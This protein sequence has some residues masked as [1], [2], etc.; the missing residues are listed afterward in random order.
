[1]IVK[2]GTKFILNEIEWKTLESRG[3]PFFL[4]N[5][6][7]FI[8]ENNVELV[9]LINGNY[10]KRIK[11]QDMILMFQ[12]V[13]KYS[14]TKPYIYLIVS[15]GNH[16]LAQASACLIMNKA[17]KVQTDMPLPIWHTINAGYK[18]SL[19]DD[20]SEKT[21]LLILDGMFPDSPQIKVEK[22]RDILF[23][24]NRIPRI[25][26]CTDVNPI[27]YIKDNLKIYVNHILY[28]SLKK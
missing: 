23:K 16:R 10:I 15:E 1:M 20:H 19:R 5:I 13:L 24:Y 2:G 11:R 12:H 17:C 6:N 25:I 28:L 26:L 3:V 21:R 14:I 18:D 7:P 27:K 8:I 9:E 22:L 4:K